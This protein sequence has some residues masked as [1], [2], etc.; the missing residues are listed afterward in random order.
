M[1]I[2]QYFEY[3]KDKIKLEAQ[4]Q[5]V[6]R[7]QGYLKSDYYWARKVELTRKLDEI[8]SILSGKPMPVASSE[9]IQQFFI[10]ASY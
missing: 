9:E 10:T 3:N 4:L 2:Q 8:E 5:E 6:N 1:T 7:A